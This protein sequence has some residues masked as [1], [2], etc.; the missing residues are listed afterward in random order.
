MHVNRRTVTLVVVVIAVIAGV[1]AITWWQRTRET[2]R[3]LTDLQVAD[4]GVATKAMEGL[5]D[6]ASAISDRLVRLLREGGD[7]QRWRAAVLLG[8]AGGA[9]VRDALVEALNDPSADVRLAAALSLGRLGARGAADR[10]AMLAADADEEIVVRAGAVRT[11]GRLRASEHLDDVRKIVAD[12]PEPPPPPP[13]EGGEEAAD[14]EEPPPD[15]TAPLRRAAVHAAAVLG[16]TADVSGAAEADGEEAAGPAARTA[17]VLIASSVAA[18]EPNATV[19][20]SAC[21]ALADLAALSP[22]PE[23]RLQVVRALAGALQSDE[24]A[25]VR[26]AAAHSLRII[27]APPDAAEIARRALD[28][29]RFDDHYWVREAAMEATQGG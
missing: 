29:A 4:H 26:I 12:R 24:V 22:D 18:N 25:D 6:R 10:I 11:L 13:E 20:L 8:D 14:A 7:Q 28:E 9:R 3:L 2:E 23:I 27:E 15:D 21:Y 17:A 5:R 19:R 1:Y 16:A